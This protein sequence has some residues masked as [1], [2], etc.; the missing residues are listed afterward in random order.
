[1]HVGLFR[2]LP[3]KGSNVSHEA[4]FCSAA[5]MLAQHGAKLP[6]RLYKHCRFHRGTSAPGPG[7]CHS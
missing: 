1:M 5:G 6:S 7:R 3:W 4:R 2:G